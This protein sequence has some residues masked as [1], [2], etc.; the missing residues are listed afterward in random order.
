[1][2][3]EKGGIGGESEDACQ[4]QEKV[5]YKPAPVWVQKREKREGRLRKEK[6][7]LKLKRGFSG[8]GEI[9]L[10]L[11]GNDRASRKK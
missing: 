4:W 6:S 3:K 7:K 1:M 11:P 2:R 5:L 8:S 9:A 10:G